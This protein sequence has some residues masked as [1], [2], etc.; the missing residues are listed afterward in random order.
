MLIFVLG[1]TGQSKHL[2]GF[3][4]GISD[5]AESVGGSI[6]YR[7]HVQDIGWQDWQAN[8]SFAGTS[9]KAKS[10]QAVEFKLDGEIAQKYD[11]FY[12]A[13][14]S[15]IGWLDWT[16]N[17]ESAAGSVGCSIPIEAVEV[18]IA[19]KEVRMLLRWA[20]RLSLIHR[21]SLPSIA[22]VSLLAGAGGALLRGT[23]PVPLVNLGH[24]LVWAY[25]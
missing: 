18:A 16:K 21:F 24:W 12:R 17:G 8:S 15:N 1:T 13:H 14:V 5:S 25:P 10:I 22:R 3:R 4:L 6:E 2:E 20:Q 9:G 11:I 23:L 7:A 19:P